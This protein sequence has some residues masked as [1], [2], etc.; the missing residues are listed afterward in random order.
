VR[1]A[2]V[3]AVLLVGCSHPAPASGSAR[4]E[5]REGRFHSDALGVDKRYLIWLPAGYDRDPNHRWPVIY[6][7]HGLGGNERDWV[8]GG[9]L[10]AT[11]AR[12]D[13]HAIVVMPDGDASFYADSVTPA[14]W[15]ACRA[16]KRW[17]RGESADDYCVRFA[18]YE[19]YLVHDL[20]G[21]IDAI[22]NT[23]ADRASRGIGGLSMGGFGAFSLAMRHPDLFGAAAS[24]SGVIA[25]LYAGPHP[26]VK[27][28]ERIGSDVAHWGE[29]VGP[30]GPLVRGIFGP[31]VAN[32]RAHDPATLI[33]SLE[34][35]KLAL[36]L[37]CGTED[38]FVLH[39]AAA[40]VHD[41]LDARG[42][43]H[44]YYRG[45]GR[46][47]FSFWRGRLPYSLAFFEHF[48]GGNR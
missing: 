9:K 34:K 6:M 11:A 45:P 2:L 19:Q 23:R 24:H 29:E 16:G 40:Y 47:D 26:Y 46:H 33:G 31:D 44:T 25:L 32:W 1:L 43:A 22:F 30:I 18:R 15:D 38:G 37:D 12:I 28:Q 8:E 21:H 13:L 7:L 10:D 20:V 5:L 14:D 17:R 4:A 36:Y 41:L 39:D 35:G 3:A 42:I 27:G 48:F